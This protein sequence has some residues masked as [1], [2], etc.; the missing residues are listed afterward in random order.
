MEAT[1]VTEEGEEADI[2]PDEDIYDMVVVAAFGGLQMNLQK[3]QEAIV[4]PF[5]LSAF[6]AVL[7][8]VQFECLMFLRMG[9]ALSDPVVAEE[10][11]SMLM[12]LKVL[13]IAILQLMLFKELLGS[14]KFIVFMLNPTTWTD[15]KRPDRNKF[16]VFKRTFHPF[17]LS[18][19]AI[20][21]TL[22]KFVIAYLVCV[23][24]VSLILETR[25]AKDAIF[26]CLAITFIAELDEVAW[27]VVSAICQF[28]KM[29]D[30]KFEIWDDK[31]KAENLQDSVCVNAV[32]KRCPF[33][34]RGSH[35]RKFEFSVA[36]VIMLFIYT[37]QLLVF[38]YA[39]ETNVLPVARDVCAMWRW[40]HGKA[41]V[42]TTGYL[43]M[44]MV[45]LMM[46][47]DLEVEIGLLKS[48][49]L[50]DKC[51]M[52]DT[53]GRMSEKETWMLCQN[54]PGQIIVFM[55]VLSSLLI[56]PQVFGP[57]LNYFFPENAAA[58]Q[59][60][61]AARLTKTH[62][63]DE[64]LLTSSPR[65]TAKDNSSEIEELKKQVQE[66]KQQVEDLVRARK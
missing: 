53:Y 65:L 61:A 34:R 38:L 54:R 47:R 11:S 1:K 57:A 17:F 25:H 64:P 27:N 19:P 45:R 55:V 39:L 58:M 8:M 42:P 46:V 60:D 41:Y 24:S 10:D 33:I 40:M 63:V 59:Q 52:D 35:G 37:R 14:V 50:E 18:V 16:Q 36:L 6:C 23:D 12:E 56:V 49:V 29:P 15:I 32:V 9:M 2:F 44:A 48:S 3:G 20:V 28:Q 4:H 30:W 26:N 22:F 51:G 13:M 31:T 43:M 21:A 62:R 66:L 5:V 7:F